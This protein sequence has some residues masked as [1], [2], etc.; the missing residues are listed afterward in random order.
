MP[1]ASEAKPRLPKSQPLD[2]TQGY[3]VMVTG[4]EGVRWRELLWHMLATR[5]QGHVGGGN[6]CGGVTL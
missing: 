2:H 4:V 1:Q 5:T 3:D 6:G